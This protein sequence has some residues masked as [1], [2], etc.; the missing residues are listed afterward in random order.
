MD[1]MVCF[2]LGVWPSGNRWTF[3]KIE[4][5]SLQNQDPPCGCPVNNWQRACY[6]SKLF[7]S[8]CL[9]QKKI[10]T[11]VKFLIRSVVSYQN[12]L[13]QCDD[14]FRPSSWLW[15]FPVTITFEMTSLD[16]R[17]VLNMRSVKFSLRCF[18]LSFVTGWCYLSWRRW[19]QFWFCTGKSERFDQRAD[20]SACAAVSHSGTWTKDCIKFAEIQNF[21]F[22]TGDEAAT[23]GPSNRWWGSERSATPSRLFR[24]QQRWGK[25]NWFQSILFTK[26]SL[27]F[28]LLSR[29]FA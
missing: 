12:M 10:L 15:K 17:Y 28:W 9:K 8:S 13:S 19:G 18:K 11:R 6:T 23:I 27:H 2:N 5:R 16:I 4:F 22:L 1:L 21:C 29:S 14:L 20:K 24:D 26:K 25:F 7:W 3:Q